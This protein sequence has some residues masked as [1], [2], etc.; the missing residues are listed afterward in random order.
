MRL[1]SLEKIKIYNRNSLVQKY[2]LSYF[3]HQMVL[4]DQGELFNLAG[5]QGN[6]C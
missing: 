1:A 4:K 6:I 5:I 3:L 2:E